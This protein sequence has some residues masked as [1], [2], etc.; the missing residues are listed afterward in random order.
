MS[1]SKSISERAH[2]DHSYKPATILKMCCVRDVYP[3]TWSKFTK[4]RT[5][6][7][8]CEGKGIEVLTQCCSLT[9]YKEWNRYYRKI[10][11][12][13]VCI[14]GKRGFYLALYLTGVHFRGEWQHV[15]TGY[16]QWAKNLVSTKQNSENRGFQIVRRAIWTEQIKVSK[17][18]R[19]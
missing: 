19:R 17:G 10:Y 11:G 1:S 6:S 5:F 16:H 2:F 18:K 3:G 7:D 15:G 12:G 9:I 8:L 14:I 13:C 4:Q